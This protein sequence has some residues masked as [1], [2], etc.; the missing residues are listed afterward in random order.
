[1]HVVRVDAT[2]PGGI[3]ALEDV[4]TLV[5]REWANEKQKAMSEAL[6]DRLRAKYTVAVRMPG[7]ARPAD[8]AGPIGE[9]K[10]P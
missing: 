10:T 7:G 8:N 3:A 5:E 1:V 2:T 6:Y 9:A 4:R